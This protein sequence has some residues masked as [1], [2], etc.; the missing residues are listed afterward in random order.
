MENVT[1]KIPNDKVYLERT[2]PFNLFVNETSFVFSLGMYKP[3]LNLIDNI[4][5][6]QI[7]YSNF[8]YLFIFFLF[9]VI[10]FLY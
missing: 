4:T 5:D 9:L 2:V 3:K 1:P 10:F 8:V 6:C 7:A